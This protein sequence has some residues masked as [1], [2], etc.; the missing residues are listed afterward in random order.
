MAVHY[1][2]R[3]LSLSNTSN[4]RPFWQGEIYGGSNANATNPT[5]DPDEYNNDATTVT[6]VVMSLVVLLLL[7]CAIVCIQYE[8]VKKQNE[9]QRNSASDGNTVASRQDDDGDDNDDDYNIEEG[10]SKD[11][12]HKGPMVIVI[13][14]NP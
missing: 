2:R 7:T 4:G 12:C 13:R 10:L 9:T 3:L 1:D 14:V 11:G 8:T 5:E 6:V